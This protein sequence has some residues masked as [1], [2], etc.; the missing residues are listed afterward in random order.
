MFGS[1]YIRCWIY[2]QSGHKKTAQVTNMIAQNAKNLELSNILPYS[3]RNQFTANEPNVPYNVVDAMNLKDQLIMK[4]E[5]KLE[6][7]TIRSM[8]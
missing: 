2:N 3:T 8:L 5:V 4:A 6:A 1:R 7:K